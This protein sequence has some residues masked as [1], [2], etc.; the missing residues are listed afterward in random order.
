[1]SKTFTSALILQLVDEGRLRLAD[2]A[3]GLLPPLRLA[4]DRRITVGMLLNHTS[5]LADYFLNPKIDGPLQGRP[6]ATWT[7]DRTLGYVG[8]R[9]V[10]AGRGMALL[11]HEL[12]APR[13]DRRAPD[14]PAARV[15]RS[16]PGCSNR[17]GSARPGIRPASAGRAALAHGYRFAG[18]KV[19]TPSR[20]TS[21]TAAGSRRSGRS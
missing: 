8:K 3:A 20:S 17:P 9:T 21:M 18:T 19:D 13:A 7:I 6:T 12:P 14:G 5:G 11:E 2:P 15:T 10:R 16:G 1:M 4:I